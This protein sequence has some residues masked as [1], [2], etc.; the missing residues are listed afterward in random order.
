MKYLDLTAKDCEHIRFFLSG[1]SIMLNDKDLGES[2]VDFIYEGA[3]FDPA[4]VTF[5]NLQHTLS[6]AY[7]RLVELEELINSEE[8]KESA[9]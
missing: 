3:C 5:V 2:T 1:I 4:Y 6:Q 8:K 9:S 7:L